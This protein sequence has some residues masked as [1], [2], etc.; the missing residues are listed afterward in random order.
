MSSQDGF[1]RLKPNCECYGAWM[2]SIGVCEGVWH[3]GY[4]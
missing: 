2:A 1:D 4:H 3:E